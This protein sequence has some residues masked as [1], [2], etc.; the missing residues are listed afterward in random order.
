MET[1]EKNLSPS[2]SLAIIQNMISTAK[3]NL[4]DDGFHF[5]LWGAL[6]IIASFAQYALAQM[7][8]QANYIPWY[9]MPVVGIPLAIIYEVR[10]KKHEKVKTHFDRIFG[11]LWTAVG[12]TIFAVIFISIKSGINSPIPFILAVVGLGTLVSGGIVRF[13]PLI[14]G[15]VVFW[16]AAFT[17]C[18]FEPATQL[19]ING[20]ATFI[21]YIIP[22]VILWRNFKAESHV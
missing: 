9:I 18:F 16:I 13:T 5:L 22:G 6:V 4:T 15:G 1:T 7:Q 3:N 21:G 2:E 14:I 11:Y 19:L 20:I 17:A 8:F 12:I 10:K